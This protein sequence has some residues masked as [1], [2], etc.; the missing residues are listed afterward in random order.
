[1]RR[2]IGTILFY[3]KVMEQKLR[4]A[5]K[6]SL[7]L[8]S[9]PTEKRNR[10]IETFSDHLQANRKKIFQANQRDLGRAIR[11]KLARPLFD[12]LEL[13][14]GKWSQVLDGCLQIA[15]ASDPLHQ[16]TFKNLLDKDLIL[17]RKTVPLGVIAVVF[18]SRPDV[19]PQ[20]IPL[21]VKTGNAVLLKG[22]TEARHTNQ[23]FIRVFHEVLRSFGFEKEFCLHLDSR[24]EFQTILK[25]DHLVDLVIPR[26]SQKLVDYVRKSTR[27]PVM[28]HAEGICHLY[29]HRSA[30][31]GKAVNIAWDSKMQYPAA[32]NSIETLLVDEAIAKE[33]LTPFSE[34]AQKKGLELRAC[35]KTR[36]VFPDFKRASEKDW[37]TEHSG[38]ILSVKTVKGPTEAIDHI[39]KFSSGHTESIIA[40]DAEVIQEFFSNI[41]S[42][43]VFS[44]ASTRF[45]DGYRFGFGAEVGISTSR[46]H[47]RGPVGIEGLLTYQYQLQGGGQVVENYLG[48]T[49]RKFI[50]KNLMRNAE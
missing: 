13:T 34:L 8:S 24:E 21:A 2:F 35:V 22:G 42:A 15:K 16:T 30:D 47:A 17:E 1:M 38:P 7:H 28:G 26:G 25:F 48:K 19:I 46:L 9:V 36:R 40:E 49:A 41:E 12:R 27:I 43:C 32:C 4:K 44:N 20:I 31:L 14:E 18:E 3:G 50:H 23:T 45:A 29:V 6:A 11:E 5:R 39:S 33:F 10:L 37:R